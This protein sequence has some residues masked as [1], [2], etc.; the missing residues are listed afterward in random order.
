M[1]VLFAVSRRPLSLRTSRI[2]AV[3]FFHSYCISPVHTLP[4]VR[5]MPLAPSTYPGPAPA[6]DRPD[7]PILAMLVRV[8]VRLVPPFIFAPVNPRDR[9]AARCAASSARLRSSVQESNMRSAA[10]NHLFARFSASF[11]PRWARVVARGPDAARMLTL[12]IVPFHFP[13]SQ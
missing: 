11:Y 7:L 6:P 2:I 3:M 10:F 13:C 1:H 9:R 8:R 12:Q 4:F 5:V